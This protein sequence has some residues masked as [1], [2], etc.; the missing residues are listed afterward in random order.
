M[1][2]KVENGLLTIYLDGRIDSNNA[3]AIEKEI[4]D[5]CQANEFDGLILDAEKLEYISSAGLRVILRLKRNHKNFKVINASSDTYEIFDMTGFTQMIDIEKAYKKVSVDGC[6]VIGR[7]AKGIIYRMDADTVVK[8]YINP[9]SLPDIQKERELA[10]KAFVL[11]IPTAISY[12]VVKV[13]DSFGSVFELLDAKSYS[14]LIIDDPDNLD[15]Y[16]KDYAV[17]LKQI[18]E[19]EVNEEDMPAA[20]NIFAKWIPDLSKILSET[21][22]NGFKALCDTIPDRLTMIHGDYHTNN[23]MLQNGETLLIDMD[24]L[25]YGHPIFDLVNVY[26]TYVGFVKID[27]KE[28]FEF[29]GVSKDYAEKIWELFKKDYFDSKTDEEIAE[30]E[31]KIRFLALVR[32]LRHAGRRG[33]FDSDEG[34]KILEQLLAILDRLLEQ[35]DSL[36][37]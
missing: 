11:G 20:K 36:E 30:I 29:T 25:A 4:N 12:D 6:E 7:G 22:M 2:S 31:E 34:K 13:G 16:V 32:G 1:N 21:Q 33:L 15:K 3:D 37:F 26:F 28:A 24:T 23:L 8:A 10:R 35:I 19:T 17:L 14:Q 5:I 27:E 9:D 18:H